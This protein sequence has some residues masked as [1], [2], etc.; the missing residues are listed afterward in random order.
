LLAAAAELSEER[1]RAL[2]Y[3]LGNMDQD[4]PPQEG[5]SRA[6]SILR[7]TRG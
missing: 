3:Y 4:M 7:G 5:R 2:D 1:A 6:A